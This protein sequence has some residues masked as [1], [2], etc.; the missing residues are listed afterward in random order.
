MEKHFENEAEAREDFV[1]T[2][3]KVHKASEGVCVLISMQGDQ[4]HLDSSSNVPKA[5]LYKIITFAAMAI[6][7]GQVPETLN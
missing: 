4:L 6:M 1:K 3:E 2:S 7:E 5:V